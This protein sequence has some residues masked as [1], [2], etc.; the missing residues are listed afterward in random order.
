MAAKDDTTFELSMTVGDASFSASGPEALVKEALE[1]FKALVESASGSGSPGTTKRGEASST[2]RA[3]RRR[4]TSASRRKA[5]NVTEE[6]QPIDASKMTLP[7][8]LNESGLN[9]NHRI[10]DSNRD[11]GCGPRE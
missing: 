3:P 10:G 1:E 7:Q 6:R 11:L 8:L 5:E 4:T 2:R 9:G